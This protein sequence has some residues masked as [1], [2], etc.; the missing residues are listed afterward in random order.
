MAGRHKIIVG[1]ITQS[2]VRGKDL[3]K[4]IGALSQDEQGS[5]YQAKKV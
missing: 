5:T 4:A 3:I 2:K 1:D